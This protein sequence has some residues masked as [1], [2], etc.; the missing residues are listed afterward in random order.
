MKYVVLTCLIL[1]VFSCTQHSTYNNL[2]LESIFRDFEKQIKSDLAADSVNG[3]LSA[4]I[5]SE[6]KI[7]WSKAFGY[8]DWDSK[9]SADTSTIYRAGSIS[10][11]FTAFLMMQLVEDGVLKLSDHVD[12][13]LPEIKQLRGYSDST[14]ITFIQLASHT[15]GLARE[16]ELEDANSGRIEEWE[17][18]LL[19]AIPKT[20]FQS[21]PGT[22]YSYSNIGF[23]ILGLALSRAAGRP[24]MQLVTE[25][26]FEPLG[27]TRSFYVVPKTLV[28]N[29]A[30]GLE[31]GHGEPIDTGTAQAEH[32]G[33]GYKVPNG[34]IYSTP[35]DLAKFMI[36]NMG[37]KSIMT[38]ES[39]D[40]MQSE[41]GPERNKYGLGFM[42]FH[43][44]VVDIIGHNGHVLGYTSQFAFD[45]RSKF[46][47]I[48]M[49]NYTVGSTDLD[50]ISFV[51][52]NN[53][54]NS[55][56]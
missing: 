50:K 24:F 42:V 31:G 53:L 13:Y 33:R 44:N 3:S 55:K 46:G 17:T 45:R 49:R 52:L 14:R 39:L 12:L 28:G 36:A 8:A 10:K 48:L 27:M 29:L 54:R 32:V 25:R 20:Y 56:Q 47:V 4:A 11:S 1:N 43:N 41:H 22:R 2:D 16:P 30:T 7:I 37:Y 21:K 40:M 15:S 23:G 51:M 38:K 19:A 18:K 9:I 6:N 35:N 5:I 34:G 26:I